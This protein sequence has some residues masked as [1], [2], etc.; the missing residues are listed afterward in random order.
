[1]VARASDIVAKLAGAEPGRIARW[2]ADRLRHAVHRIRWQ[3][4]R[5]RMQIRD[6]T[7]RPGK[8]P[9]G[10]LGASC[11]RDAEAD[12]RYYLAQWRRHGPIFK[13]FWGS[14]H[15]KI[16]V[17]G[18]PLARRLLS[19]HRGALRPETLDI[20]SLVPAE[21]LRSMRPDIHAK[22]RRLFKG[23]LRDDLVASS[24]PG[25]RAML[26]LELARLAQNAAPDAPAA[27]R[28]YATLDRMAMRTVLLTVLAVGPDSD[29]AP[30]LEDAYRR[31]GPDGHVAP[32][33]PHQTAAFHAIRKTVLQIMQ[34]MRHDDAARFEDSILKRLARADTGSNVDETVIGNA[35]YMV[36]RGHHDLRDLFRWLLKY[37]S[38]H[39]AVVA[40]L[41]AGL[42]GAGPGPG[43]QLAE[44]C[45]L[46]TLRLDQAEL[47]KRKAVESFTFE[48]F[49]VPQNSWI[50]IL[51]RESHRDPQTFPEPDAFRPHRF[52]QRS[53]SADEYA[54]FGIDE[55]QCIAGLLVKRVG[56]LFVE[57]L[58]QGFS[59]SVSGDG[60]RR[61]GHFHWE[62]SPSFAI[63]IRRDP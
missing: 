28:L 41:R 31:M 57:E 63:D 45:V 30:V 42:S 54:P 35:I 56:A 24:E 47:L 46:E 61:H 48:G 4:S 53:Y 18:F 37:L 2:V 25:L 44:A 16:C 7:G 39:P 21:Y 59:W 51:L 55:H 58:V 27:R 8:L 40:E 13:L 5:L 10:S 32:V 15:L 19:L 52:L 60:P 22:Y 62:P 20:T 14:G 6:A 1:M 11:A 3:A 17:V 12:D 34:S 26:R 36:E 38:D 50:A 33:W 23:A 9:P 43:T 49:H 29:V